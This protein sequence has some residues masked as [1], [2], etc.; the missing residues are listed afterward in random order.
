ML[1]AARRKPRTRWRSRPVALLVYM[2]W[3]MAAQQ[4]LWGS[5][6]QRRSNTGARSL[7]GT[8]QQLAGETG[9]TQTDMTQNPNSINEPGVDYEVGAWMTTANMKDP[10]SSVNGIHVTN[11][12]CNYNATGGYNGQYG[13][14]ECTGSTALDIENYDMSRGGTTC[15]PL[16]MIVGGG[17]GVSH[18][19]KD[20]YWL[21]NG[22]CQAAFSGQAKGTIFYSNHSGGQLEFAYNTL[23]GNNIAFPY[24]YGSCSPPGSYQDN[25]GHYCNMTY[26]IF[27]SDNMYLHHN[28]FKN[29]RSNLF[30]FYQAGTA[31]PLSVTNI[32]YNMVQGCC[33]TIPTDHAEYIGF[34]GAPNII[35]AQSGGYK[36]I[37]NTWILTTDSMNNGN[38]MIVDQLH[39]M[40]FMPLFDIEDNFVILGTMGGA[41]RQVVVG[42]NASGASFTTSVTNAIAPETVG[43][44]GSGEKVQCRVT[45]H[46]N[47]MFFAMSVYNGGTGSISAGSQGGGHSTPG[48]PVSS[49]AMTMYGGF[50]YMG[51]GLSN[52]SGGAGNILNVTQPTIKLAVGMGGFIPGVGLSYTIT[53]D[54]NSNSSFTGV[55]AAGTYGVNVSGF[56]AVE[57]GIQIFPAGGNQF[58]GGWTVAPGVTIPCYG[59]GWGSPSGVAPNRVATQRAIAFTN[60]AFVLMIGDGPGG[61][62]GHHHS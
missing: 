29:D 49:W 33:A 58:P 54:H 11:P 17:T 4:R 31:Y 39:S 38:G 42:G 48:N 3:T 53:D 32:S 10:L 52:G 30:Q 6:V 34:Q 43:T 40:S 27:G 22:K 1:L 18:I 5:Q 56:Q 24:A 46:D 7:A 60:A 8:L 26:M 36:L 62:R 25:T 55:G 28:F 37:G 12:N 14:M 57:D 44:F 51:G 45:G 35:A 2:P 59:E 21:N 16:S 41:S 19:V 50:A 15:I 20:N 47:D 23:D 13:Q 61:P 9:A